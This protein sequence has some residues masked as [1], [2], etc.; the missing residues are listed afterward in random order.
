MAILSI[1]GVGIWTGFSVGL[2]AA[3]KFQARALTSARLLQL[4]DRFRGCVGRVRAPFWLPGPVLEADGESWSIAWLDGNPD[5]RLQISYSGGV[6]SIDDG[7]YVSRF[8]GFS[9]AS[10]AAGLDGKDAAMGL[11][12]TVERAGIP[13]TSL[14]ARYGSA[15]VRRQESP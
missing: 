6:L 10:I 15:P 12:L 14:V 5:A 2:R 1:L 3:R 11:T 7:S 9:G 8:P 13:P 4:D